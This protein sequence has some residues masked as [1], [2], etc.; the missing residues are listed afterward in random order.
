MVDSGVYIIENVKNNKRYIGAS[1]NVYNRLCDHKVMLR[2]NY[3]HNEHLQASYNMYGEESFTFEVLEDCEESIIYSQ[4]NYWCNILDTHNPKHGYNNQP[5]SPNGKTK[6]SELTKTKMS[7]SAEKRC[8]IAYTVYGEFYKQF[9]SLHECAEE[10][11]TVAANIHRKMN[12]I[13]KKTLIDSKSSMF[14]FMDKGFSID[15]V[16]NWYVSVFTAINNQ[17]GK[18]KVYDCFGKYIGS[19]SSRFLCDTLEVGISA[20]SSAV[21]RKTYIKGL[22]ICK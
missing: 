19:A 8:V 9:N 21:K 1:R 6:C 4:E 12:N 13:P 17:E 16:R 14:I 10:F 15:N 3:H 18:Y 20:I 2:G 7:I 11:Q 22:R 5:T